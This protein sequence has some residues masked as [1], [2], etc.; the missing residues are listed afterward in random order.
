MK[1]SLTTQSTAELFP[2]NRQESEAYRQPKSIQLLKVKPKCLKKKV[3]IESC[4]LIHSLIHSLFS[5]VLHSLLR[6]Q[7]LNCP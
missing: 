2:V 1:Q 3:D 4:S 7:K 5:N 6:I